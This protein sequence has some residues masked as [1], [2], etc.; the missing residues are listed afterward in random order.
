MIKIKNILITGAR[1]GIISDVI[2][3]V[4][5]DY[6]IYLTVH[7]ESE[8]KK[9]RTKYKNNS[10]IKCFKLDLLDEKDIGKIDK[11]KIDILINNA[12]IMESGSIIEMPFK[13]IRDNFEVNLFST[14]KIT[15]K[16]IR[17]NPNAKIIIISSLAG[18]IPVPFCGAYSASKSALTKSFESLNMELK[19]ENKKTQIVIIEPGLYETGFNEYGFDKKYEFMD[20]DT[21]FK[22]QLEMI[23]KREKIFLK[24]LQKKT[25]NSISKKIE[26][27][28]IEE[29]PKLYYR[30]P[31]SQVLF[32]KIYNLFH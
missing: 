20:I 1:S 8:L 13:K 29:N 16:V 17:K 24:I 22:E 32:V 3:R 7:T 12:A 4:M 18:R 23:K 25:V 9:V 11:I 6:N 14:F 31:I 10:N 19:L 15:R 27:A 21:F 26:K 28:I 5:Y 30:A 2:E